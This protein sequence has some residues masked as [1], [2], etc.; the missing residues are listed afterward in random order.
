MC[1]VLFGH[2][3]TMS[4]IQPPRRINPKYPQRNRKTRLI[5]RRQDLLKNSGS[6]SPSLKLWEDEQPDQ[7]NFSLRLLDTQASD[8][9]AVQLHDGVVR[10]T[11]DFVE[12]L[13]LSFVVP[14]APGLLH[15]RAQRRAEDAIYQFQIRVGRGPSSQLGSA[16]P[17]NG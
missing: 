10:G 14:L 12:S 8:R 13:P 1:L 3:E 5:R 17:H 4:L 16:V 9:L 15:V 2:N 11:G 6:E 7:A